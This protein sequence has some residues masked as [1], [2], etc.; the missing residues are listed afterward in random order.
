[1]HEFGGLVF[2]YMGPLEKMPEFPQF[3][4][5]FREGGTLQAWMGPRVGGAVNCNWLQS[6]ENLM[7]ALHTYWLH[8]MHSGQ[9]FPSEF[10]RIMP[11]VEYEE[12]ELGMRAIM[13]RPLPDC[14]EW[15]VIWEMIMPM[16]MT[17]FSGDEPESGK[18]RGVFFCIP[19]DDTHQWSATINWVPTGAED[20]ELVKGRMAMAPAG[21]KDTSYEYTQRH[22]D[23]KEVMEGQGPIAIHGLE[24]L[25][26]SDQGV[27]MFR[28]MLREA[29]RAVQAGQDPKG[30]IRDPIKAKYVPTSGGNVVREG[31]V[32]VR[33]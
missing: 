27:I 24:H 3:D 2:A 17:V 18:G 9:Q 22:P 7:D 33:S 4:V 20:N 1:V 11:E 14:R 6:Q 12:T 28:S 13:T 10:S 29:I 19:V 5:W 25:A 15:D 31:K 30:V 23:D 26:T 16:T 21:R 8:T 32:S